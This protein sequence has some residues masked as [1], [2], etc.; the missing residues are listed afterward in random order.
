MRTVP[1][2][3]LFAR[4]PR[5]LRSLAALAATPVALAGCMIAPYDGQQMPDHTAPVQ[6][7]AY[8]LS[9]EDQIEIDCEDQYNLG[10]GGGYP[11]LF[12]TTLSYSGGSYS[13]NGQT[14]YPVSGAASLPA[15]CW[16]DQFANHP[17]GGPH[18]WF[19]FIHPV[20][21]RSG[22]HDD[23][24]LVFDSPGLSCLGSEL[25]TQGPITAAENCAEQAG[26]TY[27]HAIRINSAN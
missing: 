20:Y 5:R 15:N 10:P 8:V 16:L 9:T 12:V 25:G 7:N 14:V 22:T 19:A 23:N 11:S 24:V 4:A 3:R 13:S 2:M 17:P 26:G 6:F 27:R 21:V 1:G 18:A